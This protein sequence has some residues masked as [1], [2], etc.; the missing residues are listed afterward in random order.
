L[1][2][3]KVTLELSTA[4]C[5]QHG[6]VIVYFEPFETVL[7]GVFVSV[8]NC[9]EVYQVQVVVGSFLADH[10]VDVLEEEESV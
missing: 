10:E 4:S 2:A 7:I 8:F 5:G 6:V 1:A 3:R 9:T